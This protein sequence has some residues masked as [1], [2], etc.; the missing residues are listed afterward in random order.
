M[1]AFRAQ[2]TSRVSTLESLFSLFSVERNTN[3]ESK[4]VKKHLE[5]WTQK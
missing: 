2:T 1:K 3:M 4:R 5:M